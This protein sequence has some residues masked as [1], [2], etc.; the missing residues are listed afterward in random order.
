MKVLS[1]VAASAGQQ[2]PANVQALYPDIVEEAF[3][4]YK[5]GSVVTIV[6]TAPKYMWK[7]VRHLGGDKVE[8]GGREFWVSVDKP[9]EER[10]ANKR[11]GHIADG[12]RQAVAAHTGRDPQSRELREAVSADFTRGVVRY[13]PIGTFLVYRAAERDDHGNWSTFADHAAHFNFV[14]QPSFRSTL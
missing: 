11:T 10:K 12:L 7:V 3:S 4:R 14:A 13:R 8:K 5:F 9:A 2:P 1:D 6:M